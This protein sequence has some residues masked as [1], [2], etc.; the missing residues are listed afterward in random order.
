VLGREMLEPTCAMAPCI[1]VAVAP[2]LADP[3]FPGLLNV[4]PDPPLPPVAFAVAFA[5]VPSVVVDVAAAS[6]VPPLALP[7]MTPKATPAP[8]LPPVAVASA[9][10]RWRLQ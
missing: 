2:A 4:P 5:A 9:G 6:A 10:P 1:A 8:A 3:P 7:M